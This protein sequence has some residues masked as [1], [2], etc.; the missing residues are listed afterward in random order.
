MKNYWSQASLRTKLTFIL[1][2]VSTFSILIVAVITNIVASNSLQEQL[3][4]NFNSL[5]TAQAGA[6]GDL[7]AQE[8]N[9]LRALSLNRALR[10]RARSANN[11]LYPNNNPTAIQNLLAE[12]EAEWQTA[13]ENSFLVQAPLNN[14]ASVDLAAFQDLFANYHDIWITDKHGGLVAATT[15][16]PHFDYSTDPLWQSAYATGESQDQIGEHVI[17]DDRLLLPIVIPLRDEA[18]ATLG[19]LYARYDLSALLNILETDSSNNSTNNLNIDLWFGDNTL[20]NMSPSQITLDLRS[21]GNLQALQKETGLRRFVLNNSES[22]VTLAPV[23]SNGEEPLVSSLDW[24]IVVHQP[25]EQALAPVNSQQQVAGMVALGSVLVVAFIA[26]FVAQA[27]SNPLRNLS[28]VVDE[29]AHGNLDV[30]AQ[31]TSQDEIGLL[32]SGFNNMNQQIRAA[33]EALEDSNREL[34]Q[35]AYIVSHDLKAP[36]RG[37]SNLADWVEEGIAEGDHE[38]VTEYLTLMRQ[39]VARM[40]ALINGILEYSRAGR[41]KDKLTTVDVGALIHD[42]VDILQPPE[43]FTIDIS[44]TWPTITTEAVKLEQVFSNLVSNAIKYHDRP[45]GTIS[46]TAEPAP[47]SFYYFAV[48]DDGP[49]IAPENHEKVFGIFQTLHSRDDVDST[50][51]GLAVI[52]KLVEEQGGELGLESDLGAG[53]KFFFTWPQKPTQ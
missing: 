33:F 10:E 22:I 8:L 40:R 31:V 23:N 52:K 9:A 24:Y 16:V 19:I 14:V 4:N 12:K 45:D 47:N 1:V 50:G 34:E 30:Q 18:S 27:F 39:R 2:L 13:N 11:T 48:A 36:L 32:A 25:T 7:I 43:T 17:L 46:I 37:I 38:D 5:A 42:I 53:A 20:R 29:M 51:V 28:K 26:H 35:F 15:K 44:P 3:E 21:L 6:A 49:G 41:S